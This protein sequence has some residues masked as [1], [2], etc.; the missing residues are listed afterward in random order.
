MSPSL[1][2][3][4]MMVCYAYGG[5]LLLQRF[6]GSVGLMVFQSL[7]MII[8]NIQVMKIMPLPFCSE[9]V[10][11]GTEVMMASFFA[12]DLLC[13][14]YGHKQ[15]QQGV[16]LS[17]ISYGFFTLFLI[18][19]VRVPLG[20][21]AS[22]FCIQSHDAITHLFSPSPIF[23]CASI[24]AAV[25]SQMVDILIFTALKNRDGEK[26]LGLR[27]FISTTIGSFIDTV[28]FSLLAWIILAPTPLPLVTVIKTY[29][30]A[31]FVIRTCLT[32][33][34]WPLMYCAKIVYAKSGNF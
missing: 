19:T 33:I 6:A 5:C 31:T 26:N 12:T 7:A 16:L 14:F 15:A 20:V 4:A 3:I 9:S 22:L 23:L 1:F 24:L 30:G 18:T 13:E 29:I 27:A 32:C 17:F 25:I 21:G 28:V 11:M 2:N 10:A 8:A 34:Q